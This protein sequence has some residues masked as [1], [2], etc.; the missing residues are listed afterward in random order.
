MKIWTIPKK[1]LTAEEVIHKLCEAE[2]LSAYGRT[3]AGARLLARDHLFTR[4]SSVRV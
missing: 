2:V 1:R 4:K 3:V